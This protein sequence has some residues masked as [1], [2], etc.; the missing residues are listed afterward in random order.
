VFSATASGL[1]A[2]PNANLPTAPFNFSYWCAPASLAGT[3]FIRQ[4]GVTTNALA[5]NARTDAWMRV[6]AND[7]AVD[8]NQGLTTGWLGGVLRDQAGN[9]VRGDLSQTRLLKLM[10]LSTMEGGRAQGPLRTD[11][12]FYSANAIAN[13]LRSGQDARPGTQSS[14]QSRWVHI[15]SVIASELGFLTTASSGG[16]TSGMDFSVKRNTLLDFTPATGTPAS[17]NGSWGAGFAILFDDRLQGFL[18]VTNTNRVK[19]RRTGI[20]AQVGVTR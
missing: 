15:G 11:G 7:A 17:A 3:S 18:Q 13:I 1:S 16:D 9:P 19:I 14:T 6:N 4:S 5:P 10:W 20:Y 12:I 8:N 2:N